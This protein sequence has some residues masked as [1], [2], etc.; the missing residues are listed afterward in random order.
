MVSL[1]AILLIAHKVINKF[2]D[3]DTI[4]NVPTCKVKPDSV[5][6]PYDRHSRPLHLKPVWAG[7]I[8]LED[9]LRFPCAPIRSRAHLEIVDKLAGLSVRLKSR[10]KLGGNLDSALPNPPSLVYTTKGRPLGVRPCA[11]ELGQLGRPFALPSIP[12]RRFPR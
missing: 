12:T 11:P 2:A 1:I 8:D 9:Q 7:V 6:K 10:S 3:T 5:A 4:Y